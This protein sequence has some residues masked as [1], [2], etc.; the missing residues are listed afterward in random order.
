MLPETRI[1]LETLGCKLNQA[2]SEQTAR[3]LEAAGGRLVRPGET[4]DVY[5][6]NTC[7]V[8]STADAK[9]RHLLRLAHR[10]Y[11]NAAI[12]ILGCLAER[13][14]SELNKLPGVSL[15]A[16]KADERHLVG[17]MREL[18]YLTANGP[19][20]VIG[21]RTRAF[22]A[23]Q[24]GC[25]GNCT[26]CIV[27]FVRGRAESRRLEEV[28]ADINSLVAE[29]CREVVLTGTEVGS[30]NDKGLDI[31]GLLDRILMETG[32]ARLRVSS[33]QPAEI[34]KGLLAL[35]QDPRLCPH[36]H[37][38]LQSGSDTVLRRMRRGYDKAEYKAAVALIRTAVPGVAITSDVIVGF[39]GETEGEFAE[40]I[41]FCHETGFARI[42]VFAYSPRPGT[43]AAI[44][45]G[46]VPG[47]V[48]KERSRAMLSLAK[49][50]ALTF[51]KGYL[52]RSLAVLWEQETMGAWSGYTGNYIR[53][54]AKSSRE[55]TNQIT[56]VELGK[57]YKDG[58]WA[59]L[60][61]TI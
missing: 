27:P 4:P 8:T 45:H 13:D 61:E 38:A 47:P 29:G 37:V 48:K 28:I 3:D 43:A 24:D 57:H 59:E 1:A 50:S 52:G 26:Y 10:R 53:I 58:I 41:A 12:I 56:A 35:W 16:G 46:Q 49:D 11:P 15:V 18:G 31:A 19:G 34:S 30:Y 40:S 25:N 20:Q 36:F 7:T 39:P 54:Y 33:L 22:V 21:K 55:L 44:M 42:H 6:L 60:K 51:Q 17:R 32:I 14:A 23:A 5:I 9:A 2:E